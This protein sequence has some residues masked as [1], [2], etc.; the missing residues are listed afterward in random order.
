MRELE[1]S[2]CTSSPSRALHPHGPKDAAQEASLQS[3]T[4]KPL[5]YSHNL[6]VSGRSYGATQ[7]GTRCTPGWLRALSA[8][9][10]EQQPKGGAPADKTKDQA[11][12]RLLRWLSLLLQLLCVSQCRMRSSKKEWNYDLLLQACSSFSAFLAQGWTSLLWASSAGAQLCFS[13]VPG[14]SLTTLPTTCLKQCSEQRKKRNQSNQNYLPRARYLHLQHAPNLW[15]H[16]PFK[17]V[18]R[19]A[20]PNVK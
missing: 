3:L 14:L 17:Q 20:R 19:T 1:I 5:P 15:H 16:W 6:F 2:S 18:R 11:H 12:P 13:A 4:A 9:S 10:L 7:H 8:V